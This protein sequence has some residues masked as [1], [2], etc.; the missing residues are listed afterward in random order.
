MPNPPS[1]YSRAPEQRPAQQQP[2]PLRSSPSPS[3]RAL[4]PESYRA[5][6][7]GSTRPPS[8][9]NSPPSSPPPGANEQSLDPQ[10]VEFSRELVAKLKQYEEV[11]K[12]IKDA[13]V[14]FRRSMFLIHAYK[15]GLEM[16]HNL[17]RVRE[18]EVID[19]KAKRARVDDFYRRKALAQKA[20][21]RKAARTTT[22][23]AGAPPQPA[24]PPPPP[25]PMWNPLSPPPPPPS[26]PPPPLSDDETEPVSETIEPLP[27]ARPPSSTNPSPRSNARM[28]ASFSGGS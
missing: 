10:D 6:P 2:P 22:R 23:S 25:P 11:I 7:P 4:P 26:P 14:E 16:E 27:T 17:K 15:K 24:S 9:V 12:S 18:Q 5:A 19:R 28:P 21:A 13:S 3:G 8:P 20:A 1:E